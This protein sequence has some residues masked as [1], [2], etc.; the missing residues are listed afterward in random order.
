M[1]APINTP[2]T[3]DIWH[4][5]IDDLLA[6]LPETARL[7]GPGPFVINLSASSAPVD[8]P[9]E[10]IPGCQ[11]R[12]VYQVKRTEDRR[13][14]YR[15]RLGPFASEDEVDAILDSVRALYPSALTAT[16]DADD[17]RALAAIQAKVAGQKSPATPT[18]SSTVT[19]SA[20]PPPAALPPMAAK[21]ADPVTITPQIASDPA[22]IPA[23]AARLLKEFASEPAP[24]ATPVGV[25]L[26]I[27][28]EVVTAPA[29]IAK[30]IGVAPPT[31]PIA[32]S[33]SVPRHLPREV[34]TAPALT[35]KSMGV[36]PQRLP[37]VVAAPV[38][39]HVEQLPQALPSL[40][41]TQTIRA[42]TQVELEDDHALHWFVI[43]L[44]QAEEAFDPDAV[45]NLDIFAVYRL[46]SVAGIDQGRIVHSLR[47]GFFSEE[48]AAGAV[49]SYLSAFY[50]KPIIKR[51]SAAERQRFAEQRLE[52]RK[53]VGATG[54]HA[55][56]EITSE[57]FVREK[58]S[59]SPAAIAGVPSR[60]EAPRT[61]SQKSR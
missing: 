21:A 18:A 27:L 22:A 48:A 35:A 42:L 3:G 33:V 50:D 10:H 1:A 37:E 39:R 52:P 6:P 57:R 11:D 23:F 34:A 29:P 45:P 40:D 46:Y 4:L 28:R 32:K 56:I 60:I 20:T 44:A 54:K 13:L 15:L 14:R 36:A 47:L 49:A 38:Q 7:G 24:V 51:V 30:S 17:L 31:A 58:R 41:A 43:Q 25:A 16:A 12:H 8:V 59:T 19:S 53:D 2:V 61:V 55:A 26:P 9:V 5:S